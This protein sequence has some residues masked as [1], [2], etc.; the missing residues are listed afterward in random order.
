MADLLHRRCIYDPVRPAQM[1]GFIVMRCRHC[2]RTAVRPGTMPPAVQER[3]PGL[4]AAGRPEPRSGRPEPGRR[5]RKR[6]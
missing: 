2:G 3:L 4:E 6:T 1:D 5:P